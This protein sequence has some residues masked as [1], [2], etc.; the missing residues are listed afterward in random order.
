VLAACAMVFGG[1]CSYGAWVGA[2]PVGALLLLAALGYGM[3]AE[4]PWRADHPDA[5]V[6]IP[7]KKQAEEGAAC[8]CR[9]ACMASVR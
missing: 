2:Q 6:A 1:L 9:C 7:F 8:P 4:R 3:G 5:V